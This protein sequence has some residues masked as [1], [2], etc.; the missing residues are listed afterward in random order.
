MWTKPTKGGQ[1]AWL[2]K[3]TRHRVAKGAITDAG[4]IRV[5][6]GGAKF[7]VPVFDRE[8]DA[9]AH[10]AGKYPKHSA[11]LPFQSVLAEVRPVS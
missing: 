6:I 1:H 8:A 2:P 3:S 7:G 11:T 5:T 9:K 4:F 10:P